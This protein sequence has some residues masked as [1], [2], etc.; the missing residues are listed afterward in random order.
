MY[1]IKSGSIFFAN[2]R[3]EPIFGASLCLSAPFFNNNSIISF[4]DTLI[5]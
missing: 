3:G 2:A 1:A 5:A 4:L